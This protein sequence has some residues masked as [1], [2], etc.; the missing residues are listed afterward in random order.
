M[1][2]EVT[3]L[4]DENSR[5]RLC[6]TRTDDLGATI[7]VASTGKWDVDTAELTM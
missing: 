2:S 4:G 5:N 1:S 3:L 7:S 6:T